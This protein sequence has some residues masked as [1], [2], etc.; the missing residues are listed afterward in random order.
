MQALKELPAVNAE[1]MARNSS[2]RTTITSASR[3]APIR[4]SSCPWCGTRTPFS[5]AG[6]EKA[7][8]DF[9]KRARDGKLKI[10][11]M[12]GGT[13]TITNGGIYGSLISTPILN[14]PQSAILGMHR[15]EDRPARAAGRW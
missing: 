5:L 15:I 14:A 2:T 11:E 4:A 10:E 12:Q 13:F 6:I 7:I 8:A 3:S 9:G 1:S